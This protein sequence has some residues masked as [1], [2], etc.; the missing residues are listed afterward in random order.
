MSISIFS[1]PL[2]P[3]DSLHKQ[4][5]SRYQLHILHLQSISWL[6][7]YLQDDSRRWT[8][9]LVCLTVKKNIQQTKQNYNGA[10]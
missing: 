2:F 8:R 3:P 4:K 6:S 1:P 9:F 10:K 5:D 7:F